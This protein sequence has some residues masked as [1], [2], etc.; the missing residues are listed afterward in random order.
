MSYALLVIDKPKNLSIIEN[1]QSWDKLQVVI[2][3]TLNN[4]EML[5]DTLEGSHQRLPQRLSGNVLL[6]DL[7]VSLKSFVAITSVAQDNQLSYQVLFL[8]QKPEWIPVPT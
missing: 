4:S 1:Q 8:D 2:S 6:F 5:Q 7:K 3:S